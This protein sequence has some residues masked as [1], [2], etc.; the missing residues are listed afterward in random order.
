LRPVRRVSRFSIAGDFFVA[1][2]I[3]L[4]WLAVV[5]VRGPL[6]HILDSDH[7]GFRVKVDFDFHRLILSQTTR[8]VK[9]YF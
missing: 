4:F 2:A 5:V 6:E 3:D 7:V 8:N 1:I 9:G